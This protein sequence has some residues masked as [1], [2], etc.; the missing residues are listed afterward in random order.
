MSISPMFDVFYL[1][2]ITLDKAIRY[3]K[4]IVIQNV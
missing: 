2:V 1:M 4:I 3:S